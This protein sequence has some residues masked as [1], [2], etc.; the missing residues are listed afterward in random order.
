MKN[1]LF[2]LSL[3]SLILF[4][5]SSDGDGDSPVI[6][7]DNVLVIIDNDIILLKS[8]ISVYDDSS[9]RDTYTYTYNDD[10]KIDVEYSE[11]KDAY[12]KYTYT[13]EFLTKTE[14]FNLNNQSQY[15]NIYTYEDGN[16]IKDARYFQDDIPSQVITFKY[17]NDGTIY[18]TINYSTIPDAFAM[19]Y[20]RTDGQISQVDIFN[21]QGEVDRQMFFTYDKK[22]NPFLNYNRYPNNK[23]IN[24]IVKTE[25]KALLDGQVNIVNHSYIYNDKDYPISDYVESYLEQQNYTT[26]YEYY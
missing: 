19:L 11:S 16:L 13:G 26:Y 8:T 25:L 12:W 10:N 3:S 24:N 17:N 14:K 9:I 23:E 22:N 5:C 7:D 20:F 21:E 4:S 1:L 15:Y 6:D 18:R 2:I